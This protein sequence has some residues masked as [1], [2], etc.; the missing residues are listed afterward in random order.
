MPAVNWPLRLCMSSPSLPPG[1]TSPPEELASLTAALRQLPDEDRLRKPQVEQLATRL[2]AIQ[3]L[4]GLGSERIETGKLNSA[5]GERRAG[6]DRCRQGRQISL[7]EP[8]PATRCCR[9]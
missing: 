3:P 2:K 1:P 5:L 6:R 8:P 4:L 9:D 7:G